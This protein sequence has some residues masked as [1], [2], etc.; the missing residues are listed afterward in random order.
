MAFLNYE[1]KMKII[2]SEPVEKCYFT[3]KAIP[4]EDFRQRSISYEISMLPDTRYSKSMDSFGNMQIIG[5]VASPHSEYEYTIR[6][7]VETHNTNI[8]GGIDESLLGM[9]KYPFGK[10]K[11]G[12]NINEFARFLE[13]E[14]S[15]C[16]SDKE[17]CIRVMNILN[18]NMIYQSGSTKIETS[19]EEAFSGRMGVCQDFAH[20]YITVLRLLGI[21]ARYVC[22]LIVGEG[23]SHAWV[24]AACDGNYI[25]FDPTHNREIMDEYIKLGNGRDA[26]DCTINKGVMWGGGN[27]TQIIEVYVEK[28]Y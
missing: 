7:L 6:G 17:K 19:A 16:K 10:C 1:Y 9:Y 22:G 20:I 18:E 4:T 26:S 11:P 15:N 14:I 23:E 3:L 21:P 8:T 28:Y 13:G 25:A 24:E 27:Q 2:Y 5:S 12:P